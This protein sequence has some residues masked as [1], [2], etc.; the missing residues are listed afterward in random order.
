MGDLHGAYRALVQCLE[1]SGFDTQKDVLIQLGD[2]ADGHDEVYECVETLL[3]IRRI[4]AI[5]GNHDE[6][7]REFIETGYHPVAWIYG[8]DATAR[9][10]LRQMKKERLIIRGGTG[11]KTAL[12]PG[13][14]PLRHQE[15][16][17]RQMLYCTDEAGRCFVHG[18]FDRDAV[19]DAQHPATFYWDRDLWAAA[20][21]HKGKQFPMVQTFREIFI[22]H[23]S[24]LGWK[25][26]QPMRA[27]NIWNLDTGAGGGGRLTIM[28]VETKEYWQSD[29]VRELY[30]R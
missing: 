11:Y 29:P 22:G 7:F 9:S 13:D 2:V 19:L 6:W 30:R 17:R 1:R 26:D 15:F 23:T 14:I 8:G 24:T 12:N 21:G 18:G 5:R 3:T 4:I 20:L 16:F 25:T 10:Y 28:D 27:A